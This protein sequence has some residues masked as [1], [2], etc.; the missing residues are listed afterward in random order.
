MGCLAVAG[1]VRTVRLSFV[2]IRAPSQ[3]TNNTAD[4]TNLVSGQPC[5]R[6]LLL[7]R[8]LAEMENRRQRGLFSQHRAACSPSDCVQMAKELKIGEILIVN[9]F[10]GIGYGATPLLKHSS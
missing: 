7:T 6:F 5:F 4:I 8:V 9:D 1:P 3:V 10:A 2:L